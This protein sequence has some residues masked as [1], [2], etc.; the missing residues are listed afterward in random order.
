MKSPWL[1]LSMLCLTAC[2]GAQT[3][4]DDSPVRVA[5]TRPAANA[6]G[7]QEMEA[8]PPPLP[9]VIPRK[10]L[11]RVLAR[12]PGDLLQHVPIEPAFDGKHKFV[13]FRLVEIYGNDP[14]ILRFGVL[15]GDLLLA[16]N[17]Q[18]IVTPGDLMA[19][20]AVV[21][22]ADTLDIDVRRDGHLRSLHFPIVPAVA[23]P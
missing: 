11:D 18:R 4:N 14:K 7:A 23:A 5:K 2:S 10:A 22:T 3:E 13:G 8:E 20:F 1:R 9:L 19:A 16:V 6:S 12:G 21:K 17:G 15:P